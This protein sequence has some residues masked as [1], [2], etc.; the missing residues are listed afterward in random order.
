[1]REL[2]THR[3]SGPCPC[4]TSSDAF[5]TYPDGHG[6][7]FSGNCT[8]ERK[9]FSKREL[10]LLQGSESNEQPDRTVVGEPGGETSARTS[11][12]YL[13]VRG[14][15][16]SVWERYR[17]Q[18]RVEG[19]SPI[20][21]GFRYTEELVKVRPLDRKTFH[22]VPS[23][24]HR[25][26]LY[27]KLAFPQG[28]FTDLIITEGEFDA[29]SA[30][31]MV[32]GRSLGA[33]SVQSSGSAEADV[34]ADFEYINSAQRIF[35]ALDSDKAGQDAARKVASKFPF[36]K[37][38][39]V[40]MS[41]HKDA[42]EYLQAGHEK[43]FRLAF[44]SAKKYTPDGVISS[45][46]EVG[47]AL[48]EKQNPAVA[49][50]PFKQLEDKLEGLRFGASYLFSGLEGIG[51]TEVLRKLEHHV[52]STTDYNIGIIHLEEGKHDSINN[53]LT[54]EVGQP[55]RKKHVEVPVEEKLKAYKG[56]TKRDNR[57]FYYSHFGSDN[58]D[59]FL[60]LVRYL[61]AVCGCRFI[62]FDHVNFLVSRMSVSTDERRMLDYVCS[63]L[64][65]MI[66]ELDFCL[67]FICHENDNG[68]TRGSRNISQTA[69]VRVRLSRD[70]ETANE[71][72]RAKLFLSIAKNRPTSSTGPAGYAFYD[73]Q[74]GGL[75]DEEAGRLSEILPNLAGF[76]RQPSGVGNSR[77]MDLHSGTQS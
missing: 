44:Q 39:W 35:L 14:V 43:E 76:E 72:D 63:S 6:Y 51:K 21:I 66:E 19:E 2:P 16:K 65:K 41:L 56:L 22:F 45:W 33:V 30:Y 36:E 53:L 77:P 38:F 27:G 34:V 71:V 25:A 29:P 69:H 17:T 20:S 10:D 31:Q 46:D 54:Y 8:R 50:F 55:L 13:D 70:L 3:T 12:Q 68:E 7:C 32:G 15:S 58:P 49:T 40:D 73:E 60:G 47:E 23:G 48:K 26:G 37:V 74:L 11:Y 64:A 75:V 1:M 61:V 52:L 24:R 9:R 57:V 5:S 42:N 18:V 28:T 67:V 4:G 59:D 62:F